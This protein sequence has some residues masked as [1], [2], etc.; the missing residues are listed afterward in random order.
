MEAEN[1]ME[2]TWKVKQ[3]DIA[4]E[5]D[6]VTSG[7]I[8]SLSLPKFGPYCH[9][10]S[11]NGR[12]LL[13]GG[14]KGHVALIDWQK[15]ELKCELNLGENVRDVCFLHN[16]TMFAVA[17]KK[18]V[19]IY[20]QVGTELHRLK[21]HTTPYRMTFLPYHFLLASTGRE[22]NLRYQDTST[23]H[24]VADLKTR[25]GPCVTLA[26]NPRNA[27]LHL[28]HNNGAVTLWA[29]KVDE[30]LVRMACHRSAVT[31]IVVDNMGRYMVTAGED[32]CMK[33]WDL[34]SYLLLQTYYVKRP[35]TQLS[36]SGTGLLALSYG[37]H[38]Q[39][40][41]D[42]VH[43]EAKSPYMQHSL[44]E[45]GHIRSLAFCPFED[46]LG[47]GHDLGFASIVVP[48]SGQAAIDTYAAN[49][50]ETTKQR[51]EATVQRLLDKIQPDMIVLDPDSIGTV[52]KSSEADYSRN[53]EAALAAK[54]QELNKAAENEAEDDELGV[55][56]LGAE[57]PSA[58][59]KK[60]K[61]RRTLEEMDPEAARRAKLQAANRERTLQNRKERAERL[62]AQDSVAESS[63]PITT[64]SALSRFQ[65]KAK[66]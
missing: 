7:K 52:T 19:Y 62:S 21:T 66:H 38:L 65:K 33:V 55:H 18:N 6:L 48:G 31:A 26:Q 8:F 49:P 40:W 35:I 14:A 43:E 22:G 53:V 24:L 51:R 3:V 28:G 10:Y 16:E 56:I 46:V 37:C 15:N 36:L 61:K 29:P 23:G 5:V 30:P 41:K 17:Q 64:S 1:D 27:I 34:K 44:P 32:G 11:R 2:A 58:Q 57:K 12:Y 4:K 60:P 9:A 42:F 25:L 13:L 63:A 54:K 59:D 45:G 20:D 47:I 50:Y 39:V